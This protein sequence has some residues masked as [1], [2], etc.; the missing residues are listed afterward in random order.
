MLALNLS[1]AARAF[2]ANV[3]ALTL[4]LV[5]F[6]SFVTPVVCMPVIPHRLWVE[7]AKIVAHGA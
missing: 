6:M 5:V 3:I 7:P 2:I 4:F 1:P